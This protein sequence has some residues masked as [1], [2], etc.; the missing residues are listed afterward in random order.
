MLTHI[1]DSLTQWITNL[2]AITGLFGIVV[3]MAIESCCIPLPSEIVMPLAGVMIAQGT[4]LPGTDSL[5]AIFLVA[6]TGAIGCLIGSTVAYGIGYKGGRPLMLKYGRYV[7]I[8]QHDADKADA[9]FQRSGS[10]TASFRAYSLSYVHIFLT[11]RHCKNAIHKVLRLFVPWFVA[12]VLCAW[13]CWLCVGQ[14]GQ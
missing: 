4:V 1:T 2:Y 8:S 11:G 6:L 14:S 3:A 7:L 13:L 10:A 9:F 5:L 12:L